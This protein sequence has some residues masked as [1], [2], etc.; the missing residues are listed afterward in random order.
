VEHSTDTQWPRDGQYIDI[1][2][3]VILRAHDNCIVVVLQ[4][5]SYRLHIISGALHEIRHTLPEMQYLDMHTTHLSACLHKNYSYLARKV[6]K[7]NNPK[8]I[9]VIILNIVIF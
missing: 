3:I 6:Y 5:S 2:V 4:L 7:K 9:I 8:G 1:I